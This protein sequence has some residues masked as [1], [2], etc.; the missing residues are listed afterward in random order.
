M[1][2][3]VDPLRTF[4]TVHWKEDPSAR[5][6]SL[7]TQLQEFNPPKVHLRVTHP[8]R[9][10]EIVS[11]YQKSVRRGML[12]KAWW[13][14]GGWMSFDPKEY[15]YFWRRVCTTAAE[16]I[17]YADPELMN[18]VMACS[19]H[20]SGVK[21]PGHQMYQIWAFLTM[22]M[23]QN[24]KSRIYCQLSI[25]ENLIKTGLAVLDVTPEENLLIKDIA[26]PTWNQPTEKYGWSMKNN[27]R[28]EGMLKY[29]QW[30][31]ATQP[32]TDAEFLTPAVALKGLP[33]FS[34]DMH[35]RVGKIVVIRLTG[36][37][38][39]KGWL[40]TYGVTGD[41]KQKSIGYS[42]FFCEG[43][44]IPHGQENEAL[45]EL[46]QKYVAADFGVSL[47]AWQWLNAAMRA[48]LA[49]GKINELRVKTLDQQTY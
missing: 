21:T 17:G 31:L 20:F 25:I 7:C 14:C 16:D 37:Q 45:S 23:C 13:L 34:Y 47:V 43:G 3:N 44:L 29:Q 39:F 8:E 6:L 36:R 38:P 12:D 15:R 2:L 22:Q 32:S 28:G 30:A 41:K 46:E 1:S 27:W 40:E 24:E 35:T 19:V 5:W 10:W 48:E 9:K 26:L 49:D 4:P 42:L 33:D 18:F 11:A